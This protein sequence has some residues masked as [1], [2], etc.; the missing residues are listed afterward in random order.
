MPSPSLGAELNRFC[1]AA[2]DQFGHHDSCTAEGGTTAHH[3]AVR[4]IIYRFARRALER[5]G[6]LA[7]PSMLLDMRRP[8]DVLIEQA[9]GPSCR[10]AACKGAASAG[11]SASASF[12]T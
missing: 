5:I 11:S 10:A 12:R 9:L 3:N 2:C 6:L 8:T 4:D 1:G 7:D